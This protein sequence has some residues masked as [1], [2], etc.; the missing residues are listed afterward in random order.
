MIRGLWR[1]NPLNYVYNFKFL[2]KCTTLEINEPEPKN[3][4][5][6]LMTPPESKV[7]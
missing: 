2:N 4:F 5:C 1:L 6:R 7:R 3:H